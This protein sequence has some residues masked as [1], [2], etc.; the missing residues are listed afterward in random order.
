MKIRDYERRNSENALTYSIGFWID[1]ET[2]AKL[3]KICRRDGISKSAL[4]RRLIREYA[5]KES[6]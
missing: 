5:D 1:A 2:N 6:D 4:I 3:D